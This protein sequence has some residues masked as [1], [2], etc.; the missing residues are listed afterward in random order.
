[1]APDNFYFYLQN[2]LIQTSQ[3]G[4]QWYND[5]S[6]FSIPWLVRR[7]FVFEQKSPRQGLLG[8]EAIFA[9]ELHFL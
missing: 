7:T 4:G 2:S 6:P 1:M 3:T 5:T 9:A 8:A